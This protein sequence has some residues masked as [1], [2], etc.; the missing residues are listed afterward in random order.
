[1]SNEEDEIAF[2]KTFKASL[3]DVEDIFSAAL[4][5]SLHSDGSKNAEALSSK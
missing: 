2:D 5:Q 3:Y 1:M 4:V